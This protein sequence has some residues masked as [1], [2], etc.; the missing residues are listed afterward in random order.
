MIQTNI[1]EGKNSAKYSKIPVGT[2]QANEIYNPFQINFF[3]PKC[4]YRW[5]TEHL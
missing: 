3:Q 1:E 4:S 5:L 2:S